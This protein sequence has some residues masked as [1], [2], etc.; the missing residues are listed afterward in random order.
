M[1]LDVSRAVLNLRNS[2]DMFEIENKWFGAGARCPDSLETPL[3]YKKFFFK[4][5]SSPILLIGGTYFCLGNSHKSTCFFF[6]NST[7]GL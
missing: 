3:T 5:F 1:V 6:V 7:L 2:K 4:D